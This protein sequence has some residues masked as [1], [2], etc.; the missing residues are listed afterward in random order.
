MSGF[1]MRLLIRL[2]FAC[3]QALV[4]EKVAEDEALDLFRHCTE[5]GNHVRNLRYT[6]YHCVL[7]IARL[8][9]TGVDLICH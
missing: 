3:R 7:K 6:R 5:L 4:A 2:L 1:C 9:A 8:E